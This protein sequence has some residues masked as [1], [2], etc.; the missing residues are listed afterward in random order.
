MYYITIEFYSG[1][2]L[3]NEKLYFNGIDM[4]HL[5]TYRMLGNVLRTMCGEIPIPEKRETILSR[6]RNPI[7][8]EI[9]KKA[10]VKYN[11][12]IN[13]SEEISINKKN[14]EI[15][16]IRPNIYEFMQG[17]K[18]QL[19]SHRKLNPSNETFDGNTING[20]Y[21]WNYLYR[22][23]HNK[24]YFFQI[25][26]LLN[27]ALNYTNGNTVTNKNF[28]DICGELKNIKD[29]ENYSKN[30]NDLF[31]EI[32]SC[33]K[34]T[35]LS[36]WQLLLYDYKKGD[37]IIYTPNGNYNFRVPIL[38]INTMLR[39]VVFSGHIVC[40][41]DENDNE[42]IENKILEKLIENSGMSSFSNGGFMQVIGFGKEAKILNFEETFD[43][44]FNDN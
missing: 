17:S 34:Q 36:C 18:C 1:R 10:F 16:K 26:N 23:L 22:S 4:K 31:E 40:Q 8:D 3:S 5:I 12:D 9:A 14:E 11:M 44:I 25:V 21:T 32:N 39:S 29:Y 15:I 28:K 2:I 20:H 33:K 7:Y 6:Y 38:N 13:F 30:I 19:N 24:E 42:V 35:K 27:K 43:R 37:K 41:I